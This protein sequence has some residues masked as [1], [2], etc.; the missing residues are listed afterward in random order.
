MSNPILFLAPLRDLAL[1]HSWRLRAVRTHARAHDN[2][3]NGDGSDGER[4]RTHARARADHDHDDDNGD[5]DGDDNDE[6]C[7]QAHDWLIMDTKAHRTSGAASAVQ[8]WQTLYV[9]STGHLPSRSL[10]PPSVVKSVST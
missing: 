2:A 1:R 6:A 8:P 5:T 9:Y 7:A 3:A 4:R 10:A